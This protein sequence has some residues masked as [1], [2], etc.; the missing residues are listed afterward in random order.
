MIKKLNGPVDY[1]NTK[2]FTLIELL[3]A[4]AVGL[5]VMAAVY[6]AMNMAMRT[7][8][9]TGRKIATQQDTRSVL[10]LMAMEIRM[11]SF[12]PRV[13]SPDVIWST[14]PACPSMGFV[15]PVPANKGIQI[16]TD[17]QLMVAMDLNAS[18]TIGDVP[19]EYIRYSYNAVAGNIERNVSCGGNADVLGGLIP[20]TDVRNTAA[21]PL[22]RYFDAANNPLAVPVNIPAIRR[23]LIT[24]VSDTAENDVNTGLPRKMIYSNSVLVRNH[25][26]TLP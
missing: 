25:A 8:A 17:S 14:I 15:A 19:N 1:M 2:G 26:I 23:I 4:M 10:D 3:I 11:A 20:D 6:S 16:A 5:V 24:I 9:N 21:I 12:N 13:T 22:F 18:G 7:S